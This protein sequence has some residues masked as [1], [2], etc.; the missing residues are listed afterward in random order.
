MQMPDDTDAGGADPGDGATCDIPTPGPTPLGDSPPAP[1]GGPDDAAPAAAPVPQPLAAA[2]GAA[3][4]TDAGTEAP[5][6]AVPTATPLEGDF[7]ECFEFYG[8]AASRPALPP[9]VRV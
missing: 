4:P 9:S 1:P 7:G 3:T 6:A 2:D 8:N 5:A